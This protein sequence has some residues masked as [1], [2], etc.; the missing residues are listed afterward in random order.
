MKKKLS[1]LGIMVMLVLKNP[2]MP[3][4]AVFQKISIVEVRS[5]SIKQIALQFW[6]N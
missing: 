2:P 3:E 4:F 6:I 1:G 5:F